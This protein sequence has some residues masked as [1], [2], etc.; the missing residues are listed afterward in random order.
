[1]KGRVVP[2]GRP[3]IGQEEK[4]AVLRVMSGATLVHGPL[5]KQFENDF[6][7]FTGACHAVSVSS[8]T[9]ALHLVYFS[10]GIGPG[11]EVI[12]PAQTHTATAHAVEFVGAKPVFADCELETGNI[13]IALLDSLVTP[14]TKAICVVHFIGL[15]VDMDKIR[16]FA[17][18]HNLFVVEDAALAFGT[19]YKG[20]HAGTLGDAG[21]FSFYPVKHITTAEG[22]ML[23]TCHKEFAEKLERQKAFGVDRHVGE[24]KI[25]GVYDVTMLGFN[26]RMNEIEA[27][28]GIEQV[29]KADFILGMRER[30]YVLLR[31]LL[32]D[33][34]EVGMLS[35]GGGDFKSSR[36]CMSVLLSE[37]VPGK[38]FEI[39]SRMKDR[40]VGTSVYYPKP[41][42]L[43][44]YYREKY[45]YAD[46]DFPNALKI[47]STS[48]ALPVGPHLQEDDMIYVAEVLKDSIIK[49]KK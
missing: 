5:A 3:T 47:S 49:E 27:A 8:C 21:C 41:V 13:D 29:K 19:Y 44:S 24:R 37:K 26:Y 36:Y 43:M 1:M 12:V 23:T 15:P 45:G 14:R 33:I 32:S 10:L 20:R 40:G 42:P 34:E 25:P 4:D 30:N 16:L 18:R 31:S 46:R 22:G 7:K 11:D 28:I 39:V 35:A 6:A 2:F 38:R 9:A 17:S 48:I